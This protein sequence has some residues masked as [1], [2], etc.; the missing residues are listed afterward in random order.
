MAIRPYPRN[1]SIE[2]DVHRWA[3]S[4]FARSV[5]RTRPCTTGSSPPDPEDR[6]LRFF[7]AG[8]DLSHRFLARLT[9]IDYAREM[10]FVAVEQAAG[11]LLGV[12]RFVADPDYMRGEYAILVRS[13]LKGVG[14]GWRLMQHL[15]ALCQSREDATNSTAGCWPRTP[16]CLACAAI[17]DLPSITI[18]PIRLCTMCGCRSLP[19][20]RCSGD[21]VTA[22]NRLGK[23]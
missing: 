22:A 15:I 14:L 9:Q 21:G 5:P 6:R 20:Q 3:A 8:P 4:A 7:T 17:W 11:E 12:V 13:D 1:G 2:A 19:V 18:L 16:P 23:R 10:A